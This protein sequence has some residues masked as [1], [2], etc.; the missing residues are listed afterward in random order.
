M[1]C[2]RM[3]FQAAAEE[4]QWVFPVVGVWKKDCEAADHIVSSQKGEGRQEEGL[5][6]ANLKASVLPTCQL[7]GHSCLWKW[8]AKWLPLALVWSDVSCVPLGKTKSHSTQRA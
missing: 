2:V 7:P 6:C 1:I 3:V 4:D 8:L 5:C